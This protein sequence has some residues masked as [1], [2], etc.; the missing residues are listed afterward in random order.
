[1]QRLTIRQL[2]FDLRVGAVSPGSCHLL[3]QIAIGATS[4]SFMH[5]SAAVPIVLSTEV[6]HSVNP[7]LFIF[8]TCRHCTLLLFLIV[9][10][11]STGSYHDLDFLSSAFEVLASDSVIK[12]PLVSYL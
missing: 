10:S 2:L 7:A 12:L 11:S 6:I 5:P 4:N 8:L 9:T 3:S 1:M